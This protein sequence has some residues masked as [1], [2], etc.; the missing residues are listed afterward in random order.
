MALFKIHKT[1]EMEMEI[2]AEDLEDAQLQAS[3][4]FFTDF[5][6]AYEVDSFVVALDE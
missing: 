6:I 1:F 3:D 4:I 5:N 2:T